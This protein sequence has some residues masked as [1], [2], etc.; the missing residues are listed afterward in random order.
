MTLS[1]AVVRISKQ[2]DGLYRAEC[3]GLQGCL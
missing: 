3:P 1:S 2:E